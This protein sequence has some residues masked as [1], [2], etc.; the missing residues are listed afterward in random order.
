[1]SLRYVCGIIKDC[2]GRYLTLEYTQTSGT[3]NIQTTNKLVVS[4]ESWVE[5]HEDT[6]DVL[7]NEINKTL[8]IPMLDVLSSLDLRNTKSLRRSGAHIDQELTIYTFLMDGVFGTKCSNDIKQRLMTADQIQQAVRTKSV[9]PTT[10]CRF[11]LDRM[12]LWNLVA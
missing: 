3:S 11:I 9:V 1:M 6:L 7:V 2:F 4:V 8:S 5:K 10:C 12:H